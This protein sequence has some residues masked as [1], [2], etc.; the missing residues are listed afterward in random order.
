MTQRCLHSAFFTSAI[1]ILFAVLI[2][3][4][5]SPARIGTLTWTTLLC[6]F[7]DV[8]AEPFTLQDVQV[9][10]GANYIG[11]SH[12]WHVQS[13]GA[14][15]LATQ[16]LGWYRLPRTQ[17]EYLTLGTDAGRAALIA[18]CL[19]AASYTDT[20]EIITAVVTNVDSALHGLAAQDVVINPTTVAHMASLINISGQALGLTRSSGTLPHMANVWDALSVP[21]PVCGTIC[22]I[23]HVTAYAKMQAGW[24]TAYTQHP[25][26]TTESVYT[27]TYLDA[28]AA[29]GDHLLTLSAPVGV[30]TL[31]ARRTTEAY[32][33]PSANKSAL[34]IHAV[35]PAAPIPLKLHATLEAENATLSFIDAAL[36][37]QVERITTSGIQVRVKPIS[38]ETPPVVT[39]ATTPETTPDTTPDPITPTPPAPLNYVRNG[40]FEFNTESM[41]PLNW[42]RTK[43]TQDSV[44]CNT[45]E[46]TFAHNG[47]CAFRFRGSSTEESQLSQK[48]SLPNVQRGKILDVS[49]KARS[50]KLVRGIIMQ[51]TVYYVD[52]A[53]SPETITL[54]S[55]AGFGQYRHIGASLELADAVEYALIK[56]IYNEPKGAAWVDDVSVTLR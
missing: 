39:P 38:T 8:P 18:D 6:K 16:T 3:T 47:D 46:K 43:L 22:T 31:E 21:M 32:M 9:Q 51:V 5:A 41:L 29:D 19:Q 50:Q 10:F 2:P 23:P 55:G 14:L 40:S 13:G 24:L 49:F 44:L 27:L 4:Q 36:T 11:V 52:P 45:P 56:L 48:L 25:N 20:A 17:S 42:A 33:N 12:Y 7:S 1:W 15:T 30:Y 53:L 54:R 28:P 37:V 35:D 26:A 34:V